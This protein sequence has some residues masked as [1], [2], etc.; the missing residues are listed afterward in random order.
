MT[1]VKFLTEV[2]R[3]IFNEHPIWCRRW[4]LFDHLDGIWISMLEIGENLVKIW[5]RVIRLRCLPDILELRLRNLIDLDLPG[6]RKF[7]VSLAA[8]NTLVFSALSIH[9]SKMF[10]RWPSK[11]IQFLTWSNKLRTSMRWFR[12]PPVR[13]G[14]YFGFDSEFLIQF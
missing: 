10:T 2:S 3:S 8:D 11:V 14:F 5:T 6:S 7:G 9:V 4:N 13:D 1:R 12:Y